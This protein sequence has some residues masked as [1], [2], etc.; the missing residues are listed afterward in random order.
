MSI[1]DLNN[2][3]TLLGRLMDTRQAIKPI[4]FATSDK[5]AFRASTLRQPFPRCAP[6]EVGISSSKIASFLSNSLTSL[7]GL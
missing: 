7:Q 6:E 2:A 5:P 3:I 4:Y 1:S